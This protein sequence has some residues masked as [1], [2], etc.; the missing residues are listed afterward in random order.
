MRRCCCPAVYGSVLTLLLPHCCHCGCG[1]IRGDRPSLD[2]SHLLRGVGDALWES[3]ACA[4]GPSLS[5][6]ESRSLL[7]LS[8]SRRCPRKNCPNKSGNHSLPPRIATLLE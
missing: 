2:M 5:V 4:N 7:D 3:R 8:N 6:G 1:L